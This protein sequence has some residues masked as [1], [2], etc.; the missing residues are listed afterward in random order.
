[1]AA[2]H[3]VGRF[4]PV[5]VGGHQDLP[6]GG[7]KEDA[8]AIT[9]RDWIRKALHASLIP[10]GRIRPAVLDLVS[11]ASLVYRSPSSADTVVTCPYCGHW[12]E[13]ASEVHWLEQHRA[14]R[15]LYPQF[16]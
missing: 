3:Q 5:C 15:A 10:P 13:N 2:W 12:S 4:V 8:V 7:H 16:T 11:S 6:A 14:S 1:M 9:E